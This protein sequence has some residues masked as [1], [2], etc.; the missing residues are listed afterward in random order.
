MAQPKNKK[1][2]VATAIVGTRTAAGRHATLCFY[3]RPMPLFMK[4][5]I[6]SQ[7]R[8]SAARRANLFE[9]QSKN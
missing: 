6:M 7:V 4:F 3:F 5:T 8:D 1:F 9:M 2:R